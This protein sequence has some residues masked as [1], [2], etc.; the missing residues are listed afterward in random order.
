MASFYHR[1]GLDP[2]WRAETRTL[3][4]V[5]AE[6]CIAHIDLLK[7]DTEGHELAVLRGARRMIDSGSIDAIQFEFGGCAIDARTYLRDFFRLLGER[8]QIHRVT[9]RGLLPVDYSEREEVFVSSNFLALRRREDAPAVSGSSVVDGSGKGLLDNLLPV[10]R[11]LPDDEVIAWIDGDD[12][13]ATD[14]ALATVA[15]A[16][17]AGA[18]VTYGSFMYANGAS[19]FAAQADADPRNGSWTTTHLKTFRA[20]LIKRIRDEDLRQTYGSYITLA[21]DQAIMI[22]CLEM[23]SERALYIPQTLYVYNHAH[24]FEANADTGA[25]AREHAEVRRIR[26]QRRY[27]RLTWGL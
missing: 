16:H 13:L 17:R 22:P 23:A 4:D 21:I 14:H 19:G 9:P 10:W 1:A 26:A 5:C 8:Y 24:S 15:E 27:G 6:E 20:G 7:I 12:W 11:S 2:S 18:L 25:I 3:D